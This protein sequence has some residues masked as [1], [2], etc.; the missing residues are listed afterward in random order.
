M[1]F[2][3][4]KENL[5][6]L[7]QKMKAYKNAADLLYYDGSTAAPKKSVES[8]KRTLEVLEE[9]RSRLLTGGEAKELT[10]FLLAH[11][12][13]LDA[14]EKRMLELVRREMKKLDGIPAGEYAELQKLQIT[15][16][17]IWHVAKAQNDFG[18][19]KPYLEK[20][21]E[22]KKRFAEYMDPGKKPYDVWLD[23]YESG[24]TTEKCDRLFGTLRK[25]I[26]PLIGE[27]REAESVPDRISHGYYPAAA[28]KEL[29][30]Y[31]MTVMGIDK[32][33]CVLAESEHPG[34]TSFGKYDVRITTR[35]RTDSFLPALRM[36]MHEGG[37]ALYELHTADEDVFTSL[38][39][40]ASMGIHESQSRFYEMLAG[41][42]REFFEFLT[43]KLSE[44]FPEQLRGIPAG[45]LYRS[46]NRCE[47]SPV[48]LEADELTY[49]LHIMIRYELE[50]NLFEG[51][52][53]VKELPGR[54]NELYRKYLGIEIR[55]D[56]EGVL[57]DC[58]WAY[59]SIGYFPSYALG[60]AYSAQMLRT[61]NREFDV[62]KKI[63]EG[64]FGPVS[65]WLEEKVWRHGARYDPN[66]LLPAVFG[67]PFDPEVY[68]EY[69]T[70]KY[71][72]IY[73]IR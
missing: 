16:F 26:V 27:I 66:D 32:G 28:Q 22:G 23:Q 63:R 9:A 15:A 55:S 14:R 53:S 12:E 13:K 17:D 52:L 30:D 3:Q 38:G 21:F 6:E 65:G 45:E 70:R 10:D 47:A 41:Q 51:A 59:G 58:H 39:C 72:E 7:Q 57:Q 40:F 2:D 19:L 8:R 61:M 5:Y 35:Y 36:V 69:L 64:D 4:A 29:A 43:P 60:N 33:H 42:S 24:L 54:W 73:S 56:S 18:L 20:I 34:T 37:H 68:T 49:S 1:T 50:K 48:R 25:G 44:L 46:A 71:R 62:K 11:Q 31:L 67:E